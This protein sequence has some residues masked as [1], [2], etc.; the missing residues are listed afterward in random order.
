MV[1][2][3][4]TP[5]CV[6]VPRSGLKEPTAFDLARAE[7]LRRIE[8]CSSV[9]G[10]VDSFRAERNGLELALLLFDVAAADRGSGAVTAETL[11]LLAERH[12]NRV[13]V[14]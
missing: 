7:I 12:L 3:P 4:P 14:S 1:T 5:M 2:H 8:F 13:N 11:T 6:L 9:E 10:N